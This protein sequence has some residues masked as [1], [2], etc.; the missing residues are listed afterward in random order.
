MSPAVSTEL[1]VVGRQAD[2]GGTEILICLAVVTLI[3]HFFVGQGYGFHRDELATLD[4]SRHLAWGYVAYPPVTPFFGRISLALFGTSLTGFRLFAALAAA[5]SILL[6]G[7]MARE[8]GGRRAA[9]L[10]AAIAAT[11]FC[12]AAGSLMQYVAFDYFWWVS[13]AYFAVQLCKSDDSRWWIPLGTVIGLGMLTKYSIIFCVAGLVIGVFLTRLRCHLQNKWLWFGVACSLLIFLP[14]L[15]WQVQHHFISLD[16]LRHIHDRDVRIGRT[17]DFLPD[18]LK[19][20]LFAL[21]LALLGLWF[22][23]FSPLGNRWRALGWLYVVPFLL[24]LVAQGR[25]YY[26]APA[27][28]VLFAGGAVWTEQLFRT[29]RPDWSRIARVLALSALASNILFIGAI[30]LP[31]APIDSPWWKTAARLNDDLVEEIGWPELVETVARVRDSLPENDQIRLG[32]LAGNY[33]EAGAINLYGP[34]Y[35]LPRAISGTNSYWQRGY[36]DPPPE[37]LIVVGMSREFV[38]HYFEHY[39]VAAKSWNRYSV[40]NEETT[41]HADIFICRGL[42]PSW[43]EFWKHFQRY[44]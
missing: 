4:D 16:F 36:G 33:G 34:S 30:A 20:N 13:I 7:L 11:P 6:T 42:R 43:P 44:G 10:M 29:W 32:I 21:P 41:R 5:G 18:Q 24:F 12:L 28:P 26:L 38:E 35:N 8:L 27:Y 9:E 14:N 1:H 37:T 39:E 15:I 22:Y 17:K 23:F 2:R 19:L 3:V 25:G 40:A 31:L